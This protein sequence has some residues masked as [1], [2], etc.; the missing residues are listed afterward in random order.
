VVANTADSAIDL[1]DPDGHDQQSRLARLVIAYCEH[2]AGMTAAIHTEINLDPRGLV[3]ALNGVLIAAIDA[4]V[5]DW[6]RVV[7]PEE[8][9]GLL[10][11][12]LARMEEQHG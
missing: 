8:L 3:I 10:R 11:V 9:V 2:D 4:L 12:Q 1:F 6:T 5:R 7:T